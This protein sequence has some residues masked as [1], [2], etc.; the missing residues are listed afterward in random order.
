MKSIGP[1]GMH[2]LSILVVS[3][4]LVGVRIPSLWPEEV[5]AVSVVVVLHLHRLHR[6]VLLLVVIMRHAFAVQAL[7]THTA[8][9]ATIKQTTHGT[10]TISH[11]HYQSSSPI[12]LIYNSV[13]M[14]STASI[15][16]TF[17]LRKGAVPASASIDAYSHFYYFIKKFYKVLHI[18]DHKG[19]PHKLARQK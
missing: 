5:I 1:R 15:R 18:M 2:P 3:L 8:R 19:S 9:A 11:H 7:R 12:T 16:D 6:I 13:T 10:R 4:F 17:F 14:Y